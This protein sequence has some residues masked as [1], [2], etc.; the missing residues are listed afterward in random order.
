MTKSILVTGGSRGIGRAAAILAGARGWSVAVNYVGN[1]AAAAETVA[2]VEQSGGR[3]VAIRGDV[4]SEAD[5]IAMF[6]A[7]LK[8]FGRIDGL[9]NNAGIVAPSSRLADASL[10]R[11]R[12]V[13][14]VNVVGAYLCAR[15]AVRRMAR[16]RGGGGG[17]IVNVS[18]MAAVLGGAN[19]YVDYAG[20]KGAVDTMTVGLAREVG[21]DGVRVNAVRPGVIETEIHASGG[22]P[23]RAAQL[24]PQTPLGRAG[25]AEEVGEAIVWLLSDAASYVNGA[26]LNVSAGR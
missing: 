2:A 8:S 5:V 15:E 1:A 10:A 21:I 25:T 9:V 6:D 3:A 11:M 23:E 7:T 20:S 19:E 14:D 18:S 16:S 22:K 4:A 17:A 12:R 24:G 13:F 26:I